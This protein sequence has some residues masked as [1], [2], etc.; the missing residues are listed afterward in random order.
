MHIRR[1]STLLAGLLIAVASGA[2]ARAADWPMWR[3]DAYRGAA[4]PTPLPDK[5]HAHWVRELP[6]LKPAWPD[7]PRMQFD[8]C[9]EPVVVG[10]LLIFGSSRDDSVT[11]LDTR[12]GEPIWRVCLG[13][14]VRFAPVAWETRLF[15]CSDDGYLYCLE[16]ATGKRL[17]RFRGGPSDR[18]ILGNERLIS[19]WPA[20]GAPVVADD[21][22][23]FAASIWPFMGTFIHALD[24][25]T[26]RV[27]W[28]NDGDGALFIKQP[29]YADSFAGVAPQGHLVV[30]GDR[31]LIPG[32]RSVPAV[33]DRKTGKLLQ[34][35]LAENGRRGGH[36][37]AAGMSLFFNAGS[38]FDLKDAKHQGELNQ[39]ASGSGTPADKARA[40]IDGDT[41]YT[42]VA[43]ACR[44]FDL[45]SAAHRTEDTV[46]RKGE[47]TQ[48]TRWHMDE[49]TS[50]KTPPV[51]ELIKAGGRLYAAAGNNVLAIDV[52][53][54]GNGVVWSM[55]VQGTVARL[56]AADDRLF[57]VTLE[58]RIYC[59]G[60]DERVVVLHRPKLAR[61]VRTADAAAARVGK[62]LAATGSRAG[63]AVV[64]GAADADL[65]M[66]LIKQ[67]D[68]HVIVVDADKDATHSL[69]E[70]LSASD[71]YGTRAVV[72][73]ADPGTFEMPPYLAS[74]A[75]VTLDADAK[76]IALIVQAMR[77]Y[78]SRAFFT[79]GS[80]GSLEKLVPTRGDE[81]ANVK[82]AE[83]DGLPC[84][85]R[86]GPLPGAGNWTHEH[87]DAANTRVSP[88]RLVKAP[89][90]ILWFGGSGNDGVL[91]RHGHGP[92]PQ[93]IDGRVIVEGVH[94]LRALDAYT[95]RLLWQ[96]QLPGV[97]SFFNNLAHQPGANSSGTNYISMSDGIYVALDR[98]CLR[99][100]PDTGKPVA[101]FRLPLL[102]GMKESPRW[103]YLNVVG[104]YL[105]GGADPLVDVP[106]KNTK[107]KKN[108]GDDD[109][110][111]LG[112]G[113]LL[114]KAARGANDN[115][116]SSKH[117]V[118]MD[119]RTGKVSWMAS[120]RD[121]F[122]HNGI[123]VGGGRLYAIDRLSGPQL[124]RLNRRGEEPDHEA[125]LT[126]FDLKTGKRLWATEEGVFGTWLSYSAKHDVLVEAGRVARDTISDEPRGM[127]AFRAADGK[128][129]WFDKALVGPAMIHGDTILQGQGACDLLSG[130]VKTRLDPVSGTPVPWEW[131]R[132]YGC[133]TPAASQHLL[134]FRSGAAGFYDLCNDG[135]TA[136]VG[137]FRSSCTNNLIVAG[138]LLNAPDYTRTCTCSYQNQTSLALVHMPEAELWT[139]FGTK[140]IKGPIRRLGI[141][142]GAPG[143]RRADNGTL[144]IE[145]P[146]TG[147]YSPTVPIKTI[148]EQPEWFRQHSSRVHGKQS[149]VASSG[150]R[151]LSSISIGLND[152]KDDVRKFTVRLHFVEPDNLQPG[153]RL[154]DLQV[155]D[156]KVVDL[157]IVKEAGGPNRALV[158]E[159]AGIA[160][161]GNLVIRLSP[162]STTPDA[163]TI[164]CGVEIIAEER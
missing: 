112:L 113:K 39:L 19:T 127:R 110:N 129:L 91:P 148:P 117:L 38:V 24:A 71:L 93:V 142:L 18:K 33:Y 6:A 159:F 90:G 80:A 143:D 100:D 140:S 36:E 119:R 74:L 66:E 121:G 115:L 25:R 97:G 84:L 7:Q 78:G 131:L 98:T 12:S 138:G 16:A 86:A 73:Q 104:E 15:V 150:A 103:G 158:K 2:R 79:R 107:K 145:Y 77:P 59:F 31:L 41:L 161:E 67:S 51:Q 37:V 50:C 47:K 82:I 164:L 132:T 151:G 13:G 124:A 28:T 64:W 60:A 101:E 48:V 126:A 81:F 144:W 95:G 135:G 45:K 114:G 61:T 34:L 147:G 146:S 149:W 35:L 27:R 54:R 123:C 65:V 44:A 8:A 118:V 133:N 108:N 1:L 105:I 106:D 52:G 40:V 152:L 122:R 136:N 153:E 92:Q 85:V 23:Y 53:V 162:T 156:Q 55:E 87:A 14:P 137:G 3:H 160:V 29:H 75:V 120:A 62:L 109:L 134:T 10:R 42:H 68:F 17:W 130:K 141:N 22:V 5:L 57:A 99:L 83:L 157:D 58:G 102:D 94:F 88:D 63:F 155:Q 30:A 43:G 154:I 125:R 4:S 139:Y 26:G 111:D 96:I 116:S 69:W 163:A 32:G 11:A 21:T 72:Y 128:V 56:L 76:S 49:L 89:L 46:D 70:N 20:R 9:Y